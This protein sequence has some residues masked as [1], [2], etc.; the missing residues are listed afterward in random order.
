MSTATLQG[1]LDYLTDTLSTSNLLWLSERLTDYAK[2]N[3]K[4]EL[5]PYSMEEIRARMEI[6]ESELSAGLGIDSEEMIRELEAE[7]AEEDM[8][9]TKQ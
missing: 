7:F 6:A 1:L 5:K 4:Q 8:K 3:E 9:K 2:K